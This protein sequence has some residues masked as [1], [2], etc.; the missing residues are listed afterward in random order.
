MLLRLRVAATLDF[1]NLR[2]LAVFNTSGNGQEPYATNFA[3]YTN[4]SAVLAFGGNGLS[5]AAYALYQVFPSGT[6]AG[7]QLRQIPIQSQYV[8]SFL[9]NSSGSGNEFTFTFNRELLNIAN[10]LVSPSP[11]PTAG[12]TPAPVTTPTLA[13]GVGTLWNIN[14]F[15]TD[16][17][18]VPIDAIANLG[19]QDTSFNLVVDTT[20]TYDQVFTKSIPPLVQ[21][22]NQNA[23]ITA[24]E[25]INSP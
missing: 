6:S 5:G 9:P 3:S 1:T 8:T 21:V 23:Q 16:P 17:N 2:Y 24:V 13:P 4:Y 22:A 12:A 25:V 20:V 18:F 10:P 19:V 11:A 15:S 14:F 7:F